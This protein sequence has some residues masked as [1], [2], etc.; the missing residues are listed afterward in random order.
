MNTKQLIYVL[1]L[2]ECGSFSKAAAELNI[3]QPSLSQY[4]RKTEE[5]AGIGL[6]ERTGSFIRMTDAGRVYA[7]TGRKILE[8]EHDMLNRFSDISQNSS[9]TVVIGISA[10]RSV[11]L[12]PSVVAAYKRKYP[13]VCVLLKEY[14]RDELIERA[15]HGEF[16]LCITTPPVSEKLFETV[17]DFEEEILLAV[18]ENTALCEELSAGFPDGRVD[19][20]GLDGQDFAMLNDQHPMQKQLQEICENYSLRLNRTVECTSLETLISMVG[21]NIGAALVPACLRTLGGRGI[22]F[23]RIAQPIP[24]RSIIL[25]HRRGQYL[26]ARVADMSSIITDKL[27]AYFG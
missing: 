9:G 10:H 5:E 25:V 1:T 19:L 21:E 27:S 16:D 26:T 20:L 23:F 6:F 18:S 15:G 13:G 11:C 12:M 3:S 22:K 4:I 7:E 17:A 8:L 24:R 14:P 2:A